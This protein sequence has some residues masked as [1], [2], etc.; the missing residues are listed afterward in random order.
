M[1]PMTIAV[2]MSIDYARA[3]R[4]QTKVNAIADFRVAGRGDDADDVEDERLCLRGGAADVRP[5]G[6]RTDPISR[7]TWRTRPS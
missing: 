5:A 1:I 2:G 3:A 7:S 4:L 6:D